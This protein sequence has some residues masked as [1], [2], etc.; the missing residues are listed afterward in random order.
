VS[1]RVGKDQGSVV[2]MARAIL[3]F[4]EGVMLREGEDGGLDT[5]GSTGECSG[6]VG[7]VQCCQSDR[8]RSD[9]VTGKSYYPLY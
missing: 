9:G 6:L 2:R 4:V 3:P 8:R 5:V 1:T 7:K